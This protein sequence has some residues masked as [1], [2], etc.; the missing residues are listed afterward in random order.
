MVMF[1]KANTSSVDKPESHSKRK[2]TEVIEK[3]VG[4]WIFARL[5]NGT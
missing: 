5:N 4:G 2:N 1:N 3:R